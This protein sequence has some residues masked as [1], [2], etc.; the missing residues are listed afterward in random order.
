[1][2][3]TVYTYIYIYNYIHIYIQIHVQF[4]YIFALYNVYNTE[5]N[6]PIAVG[7]PLSSPLRRPASGEI[8]LEFHH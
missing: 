8:C 2:I 1:M 7:F 6:H 4:M 3:Y 5:S